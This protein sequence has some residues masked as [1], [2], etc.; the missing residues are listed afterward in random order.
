MR[1]EVVGRMGINSKP[2]KRNS[3]IIVILF[4]Y[5]TIIELYILILKGIQ[6]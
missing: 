5:C 6:I 2:A 3:H 1:E 4:I